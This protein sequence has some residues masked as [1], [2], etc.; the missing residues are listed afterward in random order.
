MKTSTISMAHSDS[1]LGAPAL[2]CLP[3]WCGGREVFSPLL[4]QSARH[5]RS[6]SV[7]WRGHGESVH[8][9]ADFGSADLIE[10]TIELVDALEV[11]RFVPV[12]LSHAGWVA[13]EVRRRLGP[14]RVPAV[15]LLDWMPLGRCGL[16]QPTTEAGGNRSLEI[17]P[18]GLSHLDNFRGAGKSAA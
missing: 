14:D 5:R 16:D 9:T 2:V 18:A 4:A 17:T 13:L 12:A 10:D 11:E 6:I 1:G 8:S 7:D 15:V 3:G